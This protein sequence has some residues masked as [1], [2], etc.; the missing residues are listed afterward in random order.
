MTQADAAGR[1]R[2]TPP[3]SNLPW[4][5]KRRLHLH[6]LKT[7]S[8]VK[9]QENI[10]KIFNIIFQEDLQSSGV[11]NFS[12]SKLHSQYEYGKREASKPAKVVDTTKRNYERKNEIP[13]REDWRKIMLGPQTEAERAECERYMQNIQ[14]VID[15]LAERRYLPQP[16]T[17]GPENGDADDEETSPPPP[18]HRKE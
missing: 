2:R 8:G 18:K 17:G 1:P 16:A 7:Q 3:E 4:T 9:K 5:H 11:A 12:E 10:K 15:E 14:S 6:L 13:A